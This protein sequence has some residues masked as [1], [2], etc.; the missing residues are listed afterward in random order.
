LENSASGVILI[1]KDVSHADAYDG[2]V[3]Q[4]EE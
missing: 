2:Q 1:L 3:A 4:A